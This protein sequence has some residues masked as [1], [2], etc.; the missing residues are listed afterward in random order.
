MINSGGRSPKYLS[1][2]YFDLFK[3]AVD[4]LKKRGMKMWIDGD[5]GYPDGFAG[6]MISKDYPQ[7]G[8]Q[9]II[10]DCA[11]H[12]RRRA[13]A[14]YPAAH[15]YAGHPGQ[16]PRR[17]GGADRSDA[18]SR[19][20]R[21]AAGAMPAREAAPGARGGVRCPG[22]GGAG[23]TT[24][25]ASQTLPV[26]ADGKLKWTAPGSTVS[27][28][29]RNQAWEVIFQGSGGEGRYSRRP[30][31]IAQHHRCPRIPRASRPASARAAAGGAGTRRGGRGRA[32]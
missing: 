4:E 21:H 28:V 15:R 5:D 6:G 1:P 9:G 13:D 30:R 12:R 26:P 8:M 2:E 23:A 14:Q 20:C 3:I 11:L 7:L 10:A 16:S 25:P 27:G 19:P 24:V 31:S 32:P 22:R 17:R 29:D 18:G